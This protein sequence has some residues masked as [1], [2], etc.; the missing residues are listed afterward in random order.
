MPYL[1]D[2]QLA[3]HLISKGEIALRWH[4]ARWAEKIAK[5]VDVASEALGPLGQIFGTRD[6][7]LRSLGL[8]Q[9][10]AADCGFVS[11]PGVSTRHINDIWNK[12][13]LTPK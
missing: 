7:G 1:T 10:E 6:A 8:T 9:A 13:V 11:Q 5:P 3:K 2:R 12:L 4:D